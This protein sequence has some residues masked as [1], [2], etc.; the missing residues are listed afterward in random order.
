MI[1][2]PETGNSLF[3]EAIAADPTRP[4]LTWYDDATG[5]R[6]ELSGAT[7]DNWRAKTANLLVDECGLGDGDTAL[8]LLPPHWQS[9]AV[10]LGCLAAGLRITDTA[11]EVVFATPERAGEADPQAADRY[12]V[13]L[14]PM[15]MPLANPPDGFTDYITAVRGHGDRF[16]AAVPAK[17]T[18]VAW[19][20]NDRI[21]T[22]AELR[23]AARNRAA[24]LGLTTGSRALVDAS[25]HSAPL[26]WLLAPLAVRGSVVLCANLDG[27]VVARRVADE[28]ATI[29]LA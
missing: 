21:L 16:A 3:D 27:A 17:P 14:A 25:A 10:L 7:L 15:G 19:E 6:V 4:I 2:S 9:A 18:D 26:D 12:V 28:K 8:V 24:E 5:E 29:V 23:A 20:T 1:I 22:H 13:G 11:P